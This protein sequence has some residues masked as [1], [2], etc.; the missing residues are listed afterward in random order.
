MSSS[1]PGPHRLNHARDQTL[2]RAYPCSLRYASLSE[3]VPLQTA[4][5]RIL[6]R[7][8]RIGWRVARNPGTWCR[9]AACTTIQEKFATPSLLGA[10]SREHVAQAPGTAGGLCVSA[11]RGLSVAIR[12]FPPRKAVTRPGRLGTFQIKFPDLALDVGSPRPV[13]YCHA[14][15]SGT[16]RLISSEDCPQLRQKS[17]PDWAEIVSAQ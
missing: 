17:Q 12:Q 5:K 3:T 15:H 4:A 6:R 10:D 2:A 11:R 13:T 9:R 14:L 8:H 16:I 1:R 7:S